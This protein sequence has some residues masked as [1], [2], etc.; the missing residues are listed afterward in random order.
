[1]PLTLVAVDR[2]LSAARFVKPDRLDI[3]PLIVL[4]NPPRLRRIKLEK[5]P[6]VRTKVLDRVRA[7]PTVLLTRRPSPRTIPPVVLETMDTRLEDVPAS[8]T[9]RPR[10]LL[11]SRVVAPD[12]NRTLS[13]VARVSAL[14]RERSVLAKIPADVVRVLTLRPVVLITLSTRLP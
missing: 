14:T 9:S 7:V 11:S 2:T 4:I 12:S 6:A 10:P 13:L 5:L 8:L 1:M 3:L